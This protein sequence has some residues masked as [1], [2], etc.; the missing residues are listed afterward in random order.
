MALIDRVKFDAPSDEILVWKFP[1]EEL[2]VAT[3]L[4][5]N[6]S[7]EALLVKGGKA[8][9]IFGPG[10]HTLSAAN[11]PL[12]NKLINLPFGGKTPF[13]AEVW[14]VNKTVKRDLKFGTN[15]P[16]PLIDPIYNYPVSVRAFGRWGIRIQDSRNFI[17]QII[18]TLPDGNSEKVENYFAGEILQRLSNALSQYFVEQKV[19]IFQANANLNELSKF[20]TVDIT[21]EFSRFGVEIVNF[22]IERI[23]IPEEEMQKF[24]EVL[25]KKMEIDQISQSQVGAAYTTVRSFDTLEKAAEN[26]GTAGAA[27]AGG[28]GLGMG[29]GAGLPAG[30][31]VG[32]A[33][34]T[35]PNQSPDTQ[36]DDSMVKLQKLKQ[37]LD[38]GL[39]TTEDFENKKNQILDQL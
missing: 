23:N 1:S 38:S 11:I 4:I 5:V 35:E 30:Q 10:T 31:Q 21:P 13:S 26:E 33:M 20:V 22:N 36:A 27:L 17:T 15:S 6:Q 25:G 9:D 2:S 34:K 32:Q 16:I 39:I 28:L 12:L 8:L 7:Q 24:Q 14:Y 3:Q 37:M 29:L 19:S 18:G